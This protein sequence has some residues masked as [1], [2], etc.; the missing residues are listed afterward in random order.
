MSDFVFVDRVVETTR[1]LGTGTYTLRGATSSINKRFS[2]IGANSKTVYYCSNSVGWELGLGKYIANNKLE[3]VRC[4]ASSNNGAFVSWG[5]GDKT[6]FIDMFAARMMRPISTNPNIVISD[7]ETTGR[8]SFTMASVPLV[9]GLFLPLEADTTTPSNGYVHIYMKGDG[10][11]YLKDS[12]GNETRVDYTLEDLVGALRMGLG[13]YMVYDPDGGTLTIHRLRN[14]ITKTYAE[15]LTYDVSEDGGEWQCVTLEG[16]PTMA[17]TGARAG[18]RL[19]LLLTQDDV[20]GR[21]ISQWWPNITWEDGYEYTLTPTPNKS[22]LVHLVCTEVT[23]TGSYWRG[24]RETDKR[25]R[26][27]EESLDVSETVTANVEV[28]QEAG[29]GTNEVKSLALAGSPTGGF[30]ALVFGGQTTTTLAYNTGAA[31]LQTALEGLS[32]IAPGDVVC[33]GGPFP[34]TP[35]NVTFGGAY[36]YQNVGE[37]SFSGVEYLTGGG[38]DAAIET[39]TEGGPSV[40]GYASV[41]A[42]WKLDESSGSRNNSRTTDY[43]LLEVG[44]SVGSTDGVIA[45]AAR[46]NTVGRYLKSAFAHVHNLNTD[47][48][49]SFWIRASPIRGFYKAFQL[50]NGTV[51]FNA[52]PYQGSYSDPNYRILLNFPTSNGTQAIHSISFHEWVHIAVSWDQSELEWKGYKNGVLASS[53][54]LSAFTGDMSMTYASIGDGMTEEADYMDIDECGFFGAVLSPEDVSAL[55]GGGGG[56]VYETFPTSTDEVQQLTTSGTPSQGTFVVINE[57]MGQ[58]S[59]PIAYNAS[60]AAV[61]TAI[62]AFTYN[63]EGFQYNT[64]VTGGPLPTPINITFIDNLGDTSIPLLQVDGSGLQAISNTT[65]QGSSADLNEIQEISIT[66]DAAGGTYTL[67]FDGQGPTAEIKASDTADD[68]QTALEGLSNIAPGDVVV[69]G[70]PLGEE[71]IQIEFQG[72]LAGDDVELLECNA[73]GLI[74]DV[75]LIDWST[76]DNANVTLNAGDGT[77]LIDFINVA[78]KTNRV[79]VAVTS[80]GAAGVLQWG[81]EVS[82]YWGPCGAPPLPSNGQTIYVELE[83]DDTTNVRGRYWHGAPVR[84]GVRAGAAFYTGYRPNVARDTL[85]TVSVSINPTS[86]STGKIE[87]LCDS[88]EEPSTIV[89]TAYSAHEGVVIIPITFVVPAGWWYVLASTMTG[90]ASF[91]IVGDIQEVGI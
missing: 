28:I 79:L 57:S 43:N 32:N 35:I 9:D 25:P 12:S 52:Q 56:R 39:T 48:T 54:N 61:A 27:L 31:A 90:T 83:A 41:I 18:A 22:D 67:S 51:Q 26:L 3:R 24:W 59:N 60:A 81:G 36:Q 73:T 82:V 49:L 66:P 80:D 7:D 34:D 47:W 14:T 17:V 6:I 21:V 75:V 1:T 74:S 65:T 42:F 46:I 29:D 33:A 2:E 30:F 84:V 69:T 15:T 11:M 20:G 78:P 13:I 87:I 38:I 40:A 77:Y 76:T 86:G 70:G 23:S 8:V 16:N 58:A 91:S 71:P 55:Y 10:R 85:V 68:I 50:D 64:T 44:G 45:D 37:I 4:Y 19:D 63:G 89:A 62:R 72:T 88:S 5:V 53:G